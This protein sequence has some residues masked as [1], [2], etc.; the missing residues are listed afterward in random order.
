MYSCQLSFV[1]R[2]IQKLPRPYHFI[3]LDTLCV[4]IDRVHRRLAIAQMRNTYKD[5]DAVLV[6]DE[7]LLNTNENLIGRIFRIL[8]SDWVTRVW[9]FQEAVLAG[10]RLFLAFATDTVRIKDLIH[11]VRLRSWRED[12]KSALIFTRGPQHV[13][14][15][16]TVRSDAARLL[17][18]AMNLRARNTSHLGD[19]AVCVAALMDVGI[20]SLPTQPTLAD[21]FAKLGTLPEDIMFASSERMSQKGFRAL[22]A[23]FLRDMDPGQPLFDPSIPVYGS[24]R[25]Q[26]FLV[27]KYGVVIH[28]TF[29]LDLTKSVRYL[30]VDEKSEPIGMMLALDRIDLANRSAQNPQRQI[31][32]GAI[33]LK[34]PL[35]PQHQIAPGVFVSTSLQTNPVVHCR[36]ETR[37][38]L[39][40]LEEFNR[41]R[42]FDCEPDVVLKGQRTSK[43]SW[44]ID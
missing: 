1:A 8:H 10:D 18:I 16:L 2:Q 39:R 24:L 33:V 36:F 34:Q 25:E 43:I 41:Q 5:A 19:E 14:S 17:D 31:E 4:P 12:A 44:C 20:Y 9:T 32:F 28:S 26:G 15:T 22:P 21:V 42:S 40:D 27:C 11:R 3:W 30:I 37:V 29:K 13:E 7:L 6:L 35:A 38:I 23:S